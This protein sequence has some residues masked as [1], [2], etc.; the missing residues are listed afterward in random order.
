MNQDI[1]DARIKMDIDDN[2][3]NKKSSIDENLVVRQYLKKKKK[4]EI[5]QKFL[6][7]IAQGL[8]YQ[9]I[10]RITSTFKHLIIIAFCYNT[11]F[12][13]SR[14]RDDWCFFYLAD[15]QTSCSLSLDST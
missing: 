5:S 12:T 2:S 1:L 13:Q 6:F 9:C 3:Y 4:D 10:E 11:A 14:C 8:E 15:L 7:D